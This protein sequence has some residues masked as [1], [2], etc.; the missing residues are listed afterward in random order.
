MRN[1]N[2]LQR[3]AWDELAVGQKKFMNIEIDPITQ[4]ANALLGMTSPK[5]PM[6]DLTHSITQA[7]FEHYEPDLRKLDFL[8]DFNNLV[9]V[10]FSSDNSDPV[11]FLHRLGRKPVG[12][13]LAD[14]DTP[15]TLYATQ[16]EKDQW[17]FSSV[18]LRAHFLTAPEEPIIATGRVIL[19]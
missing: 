7:I 1:L 5:A 8:P 18:S 10:A 16:T 4:A 17:T 19:L 15:I 13:I 6:K 2:I 3:R 14:I 11:V 9:P 12:Y